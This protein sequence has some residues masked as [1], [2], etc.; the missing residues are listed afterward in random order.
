MEL[1]TSH[2]ES[3]DLKEEI[4]G[5]TAMVKQ[6]DSRNIRFQIEELDNVIKKLKDVINMALTI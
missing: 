3:G 6:N 2:K 5:L 1:S 4:Q